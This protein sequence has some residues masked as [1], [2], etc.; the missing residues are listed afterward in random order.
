VRRCGIYRLLLYRGQADGEIRKGYNFIY[1]KDDLLYLRI[2]VAAYSRAFRKD[3]SSPPRK[4]S[5]IESN[6]IFEKSV[7]GFSFAGRQSIFKIKETVI[8]EILKERR[9]SF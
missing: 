4:D 1:P 7:S 2:H 5:E 3:I 8:M 6:I 9:L